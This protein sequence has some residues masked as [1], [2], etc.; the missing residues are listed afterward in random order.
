M[1][2]D[3]EFCQL[4]ED[5]GNSGPHPQIRR[6]QLRN[7]EEPLQLI[8]SIAKQYDNLLS[9]YNELN[10]EFETNSTGVQN[11]PMVKVHY[12]GNHE[13]QQRIDADTNQL[14]IRLQQIP[15]ELMGIIED[16]QK[17]Y[18]HHKEGNYMELMY[19]RK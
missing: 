6:R 17:I 15:N 10:T 8:D 1:N 18:D 3:E 16:M 2:L 14:N 9:A 13:M 5:H 11:I 7:E 4:L 19:P 12:L